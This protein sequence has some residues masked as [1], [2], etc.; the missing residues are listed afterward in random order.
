[1]RLENLAKQDPT[2]Q[3]NAKSFLRSDLHLETY[4]VQKI[5]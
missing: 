4:F 1:M 5:S 2:V 3:P